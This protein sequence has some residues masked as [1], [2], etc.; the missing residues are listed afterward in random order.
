MSENSWAQ[1]RVLPWWFRSAA[2]C[3]SKLH[4]LTI[5]SLWAKKQCVRMVAAAPC[6]SDT[7]AEWPC[8]KDAREQSQQSGC[9][10]NKGGNHH[11]IRMTFWLHQ[12]Q[13]A[14]RCSPRLPWASDLGRSKAACQSFLS[15]QNHQTEGPAD[16]ASSSITE[17][18]LILTV[19]S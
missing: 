16:V 2:T 1:R 12:H 3:A 7:A 13:T 18:C 9:M 5:N 6:S 8:T 4:G 11:G 19:T 15:S 17:L 14:T 10:W